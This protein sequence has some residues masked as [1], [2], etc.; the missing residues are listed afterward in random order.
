[1]KLPS[2]EERDAPDF[3]Q[4]PPA[5]ALT[6]ARLHPCFRCQKRTVC[7]RRL[8]CQ[9]ANSTTLRTALSAWLRHKEIDASA[10]R[11]SG[12]PIWV[13]N[14]LDDADKNSKQHK[15]TYHDHH[16]QRDKR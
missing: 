16:A 10:E 1:P 7:N 14:E 6:H 15:Q 11:C 13:T 2:Q 9:K 12:S 4:V 3:V 8:R 5:V